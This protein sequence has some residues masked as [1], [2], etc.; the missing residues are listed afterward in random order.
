MP[1]QFRNK[2]ASQAYKGQSVLMTIAVNNIDEFN[3]IQVGMFCKHLD[4]DKNGVVTF[5]DTNN[6]KLEITPLDLNDSFTGLNRGIFSY[7]DRVEF[8]ARPYLLRM[9]FDDI[10]NV[11]VAN[12]RNS[13]LWDEFFDFAPGSFTAA[14]VIGNEVWLGGGGSDQ[15]LL[16]N[17][18]KNSTSIINF[19]DEGGIF[20]SMGFGGPFSGSSIVEVSLPNVINISQF[21]FSNCSNLKYVSLPKATTI[22]G[23]NIF[24]ECSLLTSISLPSLTTILA[25]GTFKGC[26]SIK[27]IFLPLLEIISSSYSTFNGCNS[28]TNIY[29]PKCSNIDGGLM[30]DISDLD[31]ELTIPLALMESSVHPTDPNIQYLLENNNVTLTTV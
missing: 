25:G 6:L 23:P 5:I 3:E 28:L 2:R 10:V 15:Q 19:V 21:A 4:S 18:F 29:I 22:D 7:D 1:L 20:S 30:A 14:Y 8:T 26:I 31:I 12:P 17:L 11:P 16:S 24:L 13:S 9:L 27:E